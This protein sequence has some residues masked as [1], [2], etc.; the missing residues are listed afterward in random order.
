MTKRNVQ[1]LLVA[2]LFAGMAFAAVVNAKAADNLQDQ[3]TRVTQENLEASN[4]EDLAGVLKTMSAEM[5]QRELFISQCKKEWAQSD[6]YIRLDDLQVVRVKL[7]YAI[8]N[9]TQTISGGPDGEPEDLSD[10]FRLR[11]SN[12]TTTT[13]VLFKRERGKWK[14]VA[15]L[16]D[17]QTAAPAPCANGNCRVVFR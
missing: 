5:P 13:A 9:L 11:T 3:L 8:A 7:P 14:I 10:T 12:P 15:S 4:R 1:W 2:A 16:G 17:A 6:V